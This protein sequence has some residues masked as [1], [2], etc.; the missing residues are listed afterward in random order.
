[1]L[2]VQSSS[3]GQKSFLFFSRSKVDKRLSTIRFNIFLSFYRNL[4]EE[5]SLHYCSIV[6]SPVSLFSLPGIVLQL[7]WKEALKTILKPSWL[8]M[9]ERS[10]LQPLISALKAK[11]RDDRPSYLRLERISHGRNQSSS[12]TVTLVKLLEKYLKTLSKLFNSLN[13]S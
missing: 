5:I 12:E 7:R 2:G 8:T 13:A 6:F 11:Y 1:M 9:M 10:D 3:G 4:L